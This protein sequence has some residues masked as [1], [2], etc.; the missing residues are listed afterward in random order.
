MGVEAACRSL[1]TPAVVH[2]QLR[3]QLGVLLQR[4]AAKGVV[5]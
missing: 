1:H 3:R 2:Q 4:A 5:M